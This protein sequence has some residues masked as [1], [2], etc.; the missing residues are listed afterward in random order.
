MNAYQLKRHF[1]F[2]RAN[3]EKICAE[4]AHYKLCSQCLSIS[5]KHS[6]TCPVCRAYRFIDAPTAV[7]VVA[8]VTTR[9]AF[10][11]TAGTVPRID[12]RELEM[13][14]SKARKRGD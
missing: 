5:F 2:R 11:V 8:K 14:K 10:P 9:F 6:A 7:E 13:A 4:P 1:A 3:A 12:P